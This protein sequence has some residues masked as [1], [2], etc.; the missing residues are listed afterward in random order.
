MDALYVND[1]VDCLFQDILL[2]RAADA[3]ETFYSL[4]KGQQ[5]GGPANHISPLYYP[6]SPAVFTPAF[7]TPQGFAPG[8]F[9]PGFQ[10]LISPGPGRGHHHVVASAMAASAATSAGDF[11][12]QKV[13]SEDGEY[14]HSN[15]VSRSSSNETIPQQHSMEPG[16]NPSV[17]QFPNLSPADGMVGEIKT[18][19]IP[20]GPSGIAKPKPIPMGLPGVPVYHSAVAMPYIQV[21][22]APGNAQYHAAPVGYHHGTFG[23]LAD[24]F[25][26]DSIGIAQVQENRNNNNSLH[27][28]GNINLASLA[29]NP[30]HFIPKILPPSPG[31]LM[32]PT[33]M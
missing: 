24:G 12:G 3:L 19:Q 21:A 4:P 31:Y 25:A 32:A 16:P 8:R 5:T 13:Q 14:S 17:F 15:P 30:W 10:A 28:S 23:N 18:E 29:V 33:G 1:E 26:G 2:R 7:L 20:G 27:D 9:N 22:G 6:R 11:A